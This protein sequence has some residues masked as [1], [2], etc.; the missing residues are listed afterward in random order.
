MVGV[1][2]TGDDIIESNL[3]TYAP[4]LKTT[5]LRPFGSRYALKKEY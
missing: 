1:K 2:D 4:A 3:D 5:V